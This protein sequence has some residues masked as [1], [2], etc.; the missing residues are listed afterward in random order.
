M[1]SYRPVMMTVVRQRTTGAS[2]T[3]LL[4]ALL[5]VAGLHALEARA[6]QTVAVG[7]VTVTGNGDPAFAEAMRTALVRLTGRRSAAT[8]PA[9]A[10]IVS[11]ARRY[12]QVFRPA[13]AGSPARVTF[14][15]AAIE[16]AVAA[17]GQPV[18]N[19]T[20]PVVLGVI[21]RPP[22][23]ADPAAVRKTLETAASERGLPLKLTSAATAGL[24]GKDPI[25]AAEALAAA[26][27]QGADAALIGTAEAGDWQWTLFDGSS[28]T[29]FTGPLAAGIEGAADLFA[30]GTPA[31][32]SAWP[33]STVMI[34]M[35]GVSSLADSVRLQRLLEGLP[36]ARR[37]VLV[38]SDTGVVRF[39]LDI[40]RGTD[41][42]VE[43][44]AMRSEVSRVGSGGSPLTYRIV[45]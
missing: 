12:V 25:Q 32:E 31:A 3:A 23:D 36:G 29:V 14:D 2:A 35:Q 24:A 28:T 30:L 5:A 39:Q 41:G 37:V 8:D 21:T 26:R 1:V 42:L 16:R 27:A 40:P 7:E 33:A 10:T 22:A 44:L 11:N 9:L 38:A 20:R 43:A 17:L 4:A 18:W 45:R 13:T 19:R 6:A 34:D 15:A